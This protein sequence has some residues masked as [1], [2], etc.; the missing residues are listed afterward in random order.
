MPRN[1]STV[2]LYLHAR[3]RVF[4]CVF[5]C[6]YVC[7]WVVRWTDSACSLFE[8]IQKWIKSYEGVIHDPQALAL[9]H[10]WISRTRRLVHCY[11]A[12][13]RSPALSMQA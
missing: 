6:K 5:V 9:Y 8:A 12:H 4:V 3:V 1:A 7:V 11:C 10:Q 2:C 13:I